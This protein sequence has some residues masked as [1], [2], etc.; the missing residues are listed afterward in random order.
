MVIVQWDFHTL[1]NSYLSKRLLKPQRKIFLVLSKTPLKK[2]KK[3]KK[4][5]KGPYFLSQKFTT[6]QLNKAKKSS[7]REYQLQLKY[8]VVSQLEVVSTQHNF[9]F[10]RR[11]PYYF[12]SC[13]IY[14][15]NFQLW[16]SGKK[17][18]SG[19]INIDFLKFVATKF[20]IC[21]TFY[22]VCIN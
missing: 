4:K 8:R 14:T 2:K 13:I 6:L 21:S 3:K 9:I 1:I 5:K 18:V 19:K 20:N 22:L 17:K 15:L 12:K 10:K 11:K 7:S 16:N